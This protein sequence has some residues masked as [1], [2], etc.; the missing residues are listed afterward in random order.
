MSYKPVPIPRVS[1]IEEPTI[2]L[3]SECLRIAEKRGSDVTLDDE[4]GNDL[5]S[6]IECHQESLFGSGYDPWAEE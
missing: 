1:T 3:L 6:V 5:L 2:R 4:F